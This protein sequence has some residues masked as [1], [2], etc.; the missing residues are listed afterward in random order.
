[1]Y[2]MRERSTEVVVTSGEEPS[3]TPSR[4]TLISPTTCPAPT[5]AVSP[6]SATSGERVIVR[7]TAARSASFGRKAR[8]VV[9]GRAVTVSASA[10]IATG[11]SV[12]ISVDFKTS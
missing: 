1:M 10:P 4:I 12:T 9:L 3:T 6:F 8:I 7:S 2:S 5:G 11:T